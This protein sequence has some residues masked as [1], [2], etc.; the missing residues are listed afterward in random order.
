MRGPELITGTS[1][2]PNT[3]H[4]GA[5]CIFTVDVEDW[6]HILGLPSAPAPE[7]W[8]SLPSRVETNFLRLLDLFDESRVRVTC[9]V[10]GWVAR[11]FPRL[12]R[13]AQ[14]RGHEIASHGYGH[15]LAFRLSPR[16]FSEDA[17]CAKSILEAITGRVV[18]GFRSP[19]FSVT[20][21]V[22][23]FFEKLAEAGYL[24][25]SS[26]FPTRRLHGGL[27]GGPLAPTLMQTP[28][29]P[30]V[31]CPVS[32]AEFFGFRVCLF[33]GGYLRVA[34]LW[35]V[36][37]LAR[38]V[39]AQGRPLICYL[40]PRD[41]DPYQPRLLMPLFRKICSYAGLRNAE[42]KV[43][44]LLTRFQFLT[45]AAYLEQVKLLAPACT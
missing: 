3:V 29:G 23:W 13:E 9:F 6:F 40:H 25:D 1:R 24:Y 28:A 22:P 35:A 45:C 41:I 32:V 12:V 27:P 10:L 2:N 21:Q 18:I 33:G 16:A 26:I 38:R 7:Q 39:L 34:P 17:R 36:M 37:A 11:K 20:P 19:G 43:R 30:I 15:Q 4:P 44:S 8:S 42:R 5:R 14:A 31:E